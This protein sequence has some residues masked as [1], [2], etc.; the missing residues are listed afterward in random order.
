MEALHGLESIWKDENPLDDL[1]S[2]RFTYKFTV[3]H[4]RETRWFG[5]SLEY[6]DSSDRVGRGV[7]SIDCNTR[8][9]DDDDLSY[10]VGKREL[11]MMKWRS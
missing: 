1:N 3:C 11:D 6:I 5:E 2:R 9:L 8:F 10:I 7:I 4:Y